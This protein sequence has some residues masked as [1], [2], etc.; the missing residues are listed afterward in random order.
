[1]PV[2][3]RGRREDG[4]DRLHSEF[5]NFDFRFLIGSPIADEAGRCHWQRLP[6]ME[7]CAPETAR[8]PGFLASLRDAMNL[9]G[10][11]RGSPLAAAPG[12]L[13]S[14]LPAFALSCGGT[15]RVVVFR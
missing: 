4:S 9:A 14:T 13:L 12:Y 3:K 1:M 11:Y 2:E 7:C 15:G 10:R 8:G 6:V 5:L